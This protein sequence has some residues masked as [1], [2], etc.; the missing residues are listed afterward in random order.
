[1]QPPVAA[2]AATVGQA[3]SAGPAAAQPAAAAAAAAHGS[4]SSPGLSYQA[5]QAKIKFKDV[6]QAES[7]L[8]EL[9]REGGGAARLPLAK[10]AAVTGGGVALCP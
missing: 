1:M 2:A 7:F 4:S 10:S 8:G 3:G 6:Q 5:V 9:A